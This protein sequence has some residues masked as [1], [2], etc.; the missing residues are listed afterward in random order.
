MLHDRTAAVAAIVGATFSALCLAGIVYL[1]CR[2]AVHLVDRPQAAHRQVPREADGRA[3]LSPLSIELARAPDPGDG[4]THMVITLDYVNVGRQPTDGVAIA[5][6]SGALE[7][8]L[9][10][11][12]LGAV[13]SGENPTCNGLVPPTKGQIVF[14]SSLVPRAYS[15]TDL[16]S[17]EWSIAR[18]KSIFIVQ[19]CLAYRTNGVVHHTRLCEFVEP[20]PGQP[21]EKGRMHFCADGNDAD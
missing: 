2:P 19:A 3:W 8:P 13:T 11:T 12:A 16:M 6:R 18:K 7:R 15:Q 14:P 10:S 5:M 20:L 1:A 17:G 21:I 4:T 9:T